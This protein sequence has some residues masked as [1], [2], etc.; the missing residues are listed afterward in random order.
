MNE[1]LSPERIQGIVQTAIDDA[2]DYVET[3]LSDDRIKAQRYYNGKVDL[4]SEEGRSQVIAT[5]CRDVVRW[6][7]PALIKVFLQ[8]DKPVEFVPRTPEDVPLAEQQTEF[9]NYLFGRSNGYRV[10][11]DCI[12]DALT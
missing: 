3:Y 4:P 11:S 9:A 2:C 1:P 6:A 5:K 8:S 7:K 12:H 10:I